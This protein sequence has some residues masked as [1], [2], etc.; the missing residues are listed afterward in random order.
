MTTETPVGDNTPTAATP[1]A[2]AGTPAPS[3]RRPQ[4][5][6]TSGRARH[7]NLNINVKSAGS[8][9]GAWRSPDTDLSAVNDFGALRALAGR[10][11]A[12]GID[13]LFFADGLNYSARSGAGAPPPVFEP[14]SLLGALAASTT[15][16]GL[17]ATMSTTYNEPYNLARQMSSLDWISNGRVGWNIVTTGGGGAAA[18]FG[19][20]EHPEHDERYRRAVEF[21]TVACKLWESWDPDAV[22]ADRSTGIY[23][24]PAKVH[25]IDHHGDVFR[26]AGPLN[27]PR[28]PQGR[29]L[30]VQ[31]G[32][33]E[34]GRDL[35]A[36]HAD[37]VYTIS[38]TVQDARELY[39]DLKSR[40]VAYGRDPDSIKVVMGIRVLVAPTRREAEDTAARLE[41]LNDPRRVLQHVG[42]LIGVDLARLPL[43]APVPLLPEATSTN[44]IQTHLQLLHELIAR[45][46]P[47]TIRELVGR[48]Q[49]GVGAL[50]VTGDGADVA[51]FLEEW[52]RAGVV[53]GFNV[54]L[55]MLQGGAENFFDLVVPELRR[56]GLR[57][58]D[59]PGT[60]L[61]DRYGLPARPKERV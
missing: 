2:A 10:A 57:P 28:S 46:R 50:T 51:D 30:L 61:R 34:P 41:E 8:H 25:P 14:V 13:A 12:A 17:I 47:A 54:G 3:G 32:G 58:D 5:G 31:A 52:V 42:G 48:L 21:V 23:V 49:G 6:C 27:S 45:E 1:S 33:S 24:D 29:P 16:L 59:Y 18:N 22:V 40:V 56:R 19:L 15:R 36:Q 60:T 39:D 43:D 35:A 4:P 53:D 11:E 20:A 7:I 55:Q 44:A 38:Q 37:V 9:D 26:V